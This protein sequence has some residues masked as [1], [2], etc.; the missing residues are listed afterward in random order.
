LA[1]RPKGKE[2]TIIYLKF[3][4]ADAAAALIQEVLSGG[5]GGDSE[6]GG[7]GSLMGDLMEG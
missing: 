7:G 1:T 3:A 5:A 2:L 6:G 4:K